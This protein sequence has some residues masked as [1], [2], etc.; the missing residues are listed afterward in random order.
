MNTEEK[1][2]YL[3]EW[4]GN[5]RDKSTAYCKKWRHKSEENMDKANKG[6]STWHNNNKEWNRQ[7]DLN[8]PIMRMV[9][10]AKQ[11]A[12]KRGLE[13]S[14][15]ETDIERVTHCPIYGIE[16]SYTNKNKKQDNSASLDRVDNNKGYIPGN[17]KIISS[18]AN[19]EKRNLT[20]VQLELIKQYILNNSKK[21]T[22]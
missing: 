12:K 20:L 1:N 4:Q 19:T 5:N 16:L 6:S 18:K 7:Y 22:P 9:I 14:I 8:H 21:E 2:K 11:N 15:T 17:V 10:R 3:R 13:F